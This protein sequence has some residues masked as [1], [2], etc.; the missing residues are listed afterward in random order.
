MILTGQK[1]LK[2]KIFKDKSQKDEENCP[3]CEEN[4]LTFYD[5]LH[6]ALAMLYDAKIVST[7]DKYDSVVGVIRIDPYSLT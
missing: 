4:K 5:S 3:L 7:D 1:I 6:A 2:I